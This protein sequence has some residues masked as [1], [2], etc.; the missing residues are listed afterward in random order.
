MT[1]LILRNEFTKELEIDT[2]NFLDISESE[3]RNLINEDIYEKAKLIIDNLFVIKSS[4]IINLAKE[5]SRF[6][7]LKLLRLY[8]N[9]QIYII[10]DDYENIKII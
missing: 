3:Y 4:M 10:I 2:T 5:I 1:I 9:K 6:S 8:K 7:N